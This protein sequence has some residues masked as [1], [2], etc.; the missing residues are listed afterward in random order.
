M[1]SSSNSMLHHFLEVLWFYI[2]LFLHHVKCLGEL[3]VAD[4]F[5]R[6]P[7]SCL[8]PFPLSWNEDT[9]AAALASTM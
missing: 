1:F 2:I 4:L 7:S 5:E 8:C 9:K 6:Q 3:K